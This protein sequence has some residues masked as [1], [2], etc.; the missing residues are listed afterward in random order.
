MSGK[1]PT[2]ETRDPTKVP[3]ENFQVCERRGDLEL[4]KSIV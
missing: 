1:I 2:H 4:I 3:E